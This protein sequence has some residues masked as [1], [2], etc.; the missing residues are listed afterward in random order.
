MGKT[1]SANIRSMHGSI[2][3]LVSQTCCTEITALEKFSQMPAL[4][5]YVLASQLKYV[6]CE[7]SEKQHVDVCAMF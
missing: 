5:A 1:A 4:I 2:L 7:C 3:V 6:I